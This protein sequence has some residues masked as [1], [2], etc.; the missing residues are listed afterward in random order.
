MVAFSKDGKE[1][2]MARYNARSSGP[3][4]ESYKLVK[5]Y[6]FLLL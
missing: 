5:N 4:P 1:Y 6:K 2:K 3:R